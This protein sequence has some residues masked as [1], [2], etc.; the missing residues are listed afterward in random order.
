MATAYLTIDVEVGREKAVRDALRRVPG[1]KRADMVTG[2]H[3]VFAVVEASSVESLVA[4]VLKKIRSVKGIRKTNT[5]IAV[6]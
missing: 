2:R 5:H 4:A 6:E 3:D 1:V